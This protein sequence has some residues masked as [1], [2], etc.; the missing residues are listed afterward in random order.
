MAGEQ[1]PIHIWSEQDLTKT[2]TPNQIPREKN[3]KR[4]REDKERGG[5]GGQGWLYEKKAPRHFDH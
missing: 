2:V 4:K 5:G 3:T 1:G